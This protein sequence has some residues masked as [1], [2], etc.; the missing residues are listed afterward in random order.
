MAVENIN[1][2]DVCTRCGQRLDGSR[3]NESDKDYHRHNLCIKNIE[4]GGQ[5]EEAIKLGGILTK[6]SKDK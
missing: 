1:G 2:I 6:I 3:V 5:V 4:E